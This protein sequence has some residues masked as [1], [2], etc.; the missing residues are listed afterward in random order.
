VR[1]YLY[2]SLTLLFLLAA[3]G[4]AYWGK[5]HVP[6]TIA[7]MEDTE[8][9][10]W[11]P[12]RGESVAGLELDV[13]AAEGAAGAVDEFIRRPL[14][15]S[16]RRPFVPSP[17]AAILNETMAQAIAAPAPPEPLPVPSADPPTFFLKGIMVDGGY[18][19]ALVATASDSIP[20]WHST[21]SKIDGWEVA[22]ISDNEIILLHGSQ[23]IRLKQYVDKVSPA[24]AGD[25]PQ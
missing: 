3:C 9:E 22:A 17:P 6:A 1:S 24:V 23:E 8:A 2:K 7:R 10:V 4:A 21:G 12:P 20:K 19:E 15:L 25:N 5:V 13:A 18:R 11:A 16:S 14:F